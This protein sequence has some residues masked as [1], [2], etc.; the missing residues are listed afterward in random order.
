MDPDPVLAS[1]GLQEHLLQAVTASH[2]AP[3]SLSPRHCLVWGDSSHLRTIPLS[4]SIKA[5]VYPACRFEADVSF[6]SS[7]PDHS[8][9]LLKAR[10]YVLW[11]LLEGLFLP[12][13]SLIHYLSLFC[14]G[15][16]KVEGFKKRSTEDRG[17]LELLRKEITQV[18]ASG[19]DVRRLYIACW[20]GQPSHA[21]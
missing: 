15:F 16:G 13:A 8:S 14:V 7:H 11:L 2:G 12:A 1:R 9:C 6:V 5:S 20:L 3:D 4:G 18:K 21:S 17:N 10:E 19:K